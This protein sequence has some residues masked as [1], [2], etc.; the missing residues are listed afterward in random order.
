MAGLIE[1][2]A[3]VA[4]SVRD[5]GLGADLR[6]DAVRRILDVVGNCLGAAGEPVAEAARAVAREWGTGGPAT[7][8]ADD[9]PLPAAGAAFVN[10]VLAHALDFDDTHLPSVLHPSA[11]VVP[12]A[13]AAAE[14]YGATG[15]ALLDAVVMGL[16]VCVRLGMAGYDEKLGNSVFFERGQHATSICGAVGASVAVAMLA[17]L[18]APG[19]A[20]AAGIAASMGAGLL[21]ANRTGGTVKRIHCGWASHSAVSA[22][23]LARHGVTG[24]PTVL[25]GRFG[26]FQAWCGD[27]ADPEYVT[28]ELGERWETPGVFFKPYPC[29]HFTQAGIDAALE[30]RGRG[31]DPAEV[32]EA[33][34]RA[35]APVL[36]TIAEPREVKIA[37]PTGYNAAFSGPY[38][39]AAALLG[40]GGLGVGFADFTDE[41]AHDP[42]R[43]ELAAKVRC[44]ADDALG[45]IYPYQF[46]AQLWV[47]TRDG[48]EWQCRVEQ[49]RGGPDR[50]LSDAEHAV[51]FEMT[52]GRTVAAETIPRLREAVTALATNGT[53]ADL[54]RLLRVRS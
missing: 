34:L 6:A 18:D 17:G 7:V 20:S 42:R 33:E 47:R 53:V 35:P 43:R 16:E 3:E 22:A 27:Q 51:K 10:G 28:R 4:V 49:N 5:G 13:L 30:L 1:R 25:E 52:A 14:Q 29:N 23:A 37:P 39:V 11:S 24:P 50:P 45:R 44:V 15:P 12:A 8:I 40:G 31:L 36:R 41:A 48:R 26:F 38:T 54:T 19:I 21:E 9:R 46:P 2:V 32:V